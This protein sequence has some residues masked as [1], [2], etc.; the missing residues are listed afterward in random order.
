[1]KSVSGYS[2]LIPL[3][4][5][6]LVGCTTAAPAE[7]GTTTDGSVV[8]QPAQAGGEGPALSSL[9]ATLPDPAT[10]PD[11]IPD[12]LPMPVGKF[13]AGSDYTC[14][15]QFLCEYGYS[16]MF[17]VESYEVAEKLAADLE[18]YGHVETDYNEFS[19]GARRVRFTEGPEVRAN[20]VIDDPSWTEHLVI[21]Y[22]IEPQGT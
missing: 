10:L 9:E 14:G 2:L 16:L 19:D 20:V 8:E 15:D 18:A 4:A 12:D 6:L 13:E 21:E 7:T 17:L 11:W 3:A 5:L 22:N 1:M